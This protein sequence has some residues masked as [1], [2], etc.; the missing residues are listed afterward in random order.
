MNDVDK[1]GAY[2]PGDE[3]APANDAVALSLPKRVGRYRVEKVL[4]KGG[5]GLVYLAH[6]DQLH[7]LVAIKVPHA[8]LVVRSTDAEAYLTEA[9]T[10]ANLD[11][12]HIVPVFDV[13]STPDCPCFVVSKYIDGTDLSARLKQSRL[14][15]LEAV[16]LVATV[17]ETLHHAHKQGLVHRD[18]KPGNIL[19][20]KSG[21]PF[22]GD[23]GLALREQDVGKG[24]R[25]VGTPAYMSPEQA[26]CEG[27][28]VDGRSD[29]FSLGAVFY[30]LLVGHR[31]FKADSQDDLLDQIANVDVRPPRQWDDAIPKE[32]ERICLKSLSKRA[33][34]RYSA[35][36]DMADDLR[37][38]L[39]NASVESKPTL[40]NRGKS[41]AA[42]AT[43]VPTP[44][45]PPVSDRQPIKIVP[46]GLRSFDA[47]DADFF[48]ELL[49]GPRDREGLPDSIRFWKN[50]IEERDAENTFAVGL[51][52]GPSG[53]GKSSLVKA[54]LLP[55]LSDD[56]IAVYLEATAG[57]T[58]ARL[59][60]GLRKKCPA[61][62]ANIGVKETLAALRRGHGIPAG[63]KVLI[64]IDQFEQWLH[65]KMEVEN[66]DLV[67]ALRQCDGGRVQCIVMVRDDFWM[68]A[69]RFMRDLEVRLLEGQNSAAVDLFDMDHAK[70]VLAAF[71]RAFGK[72]PENA[73][74]ADKEQ[75]EFLKQAV[76]G[77]AQEGKVICVRLALFAEMMKGKAWTPASLR[78]VGGTEG[79]G[80]TFLEETFSTASSP[81]EHRYHQKAARADLRVL[82]PETGS[83]IKG[84][85][86]SYAELLEASGYGN[87]PK[88]F[89]ELLRI[90]D[91]EIRLI[92]PTDPEGKEADG[93]S[94]LQTKPGQKYY[95]LTHDYL[96]HSIREWLTRKQKETRRGRAELLLADRAA[97]WNARPENRQLPSLL[98]WF[99]IRLSAAKRNW[100]PPQS[101]M[102]RQAGR[103]HAMRGAVVAVVLALIGWGGYETRGAMRATA[104]L[105][106]LLDANTADVPI[107]VKDMESYR[108]WIDPLLRNASSDAEANKVARKQLHASL[109][110]LPVDPG[111][112]DYLS[113][114]LLDAQ[115]HEV[116]VI[117]DALAPHKDGLLDNL[118]SVVLTP[119]K[120]KQAQRLRAAAA[121]AKY[122][123]E[124]E[125]WTTSSPLVVTDLVQEN[126]VFLG[127]WSE[128]YRPVKNSLLDPLAVHFR[129]QRPE[130]SAERTLATNLLADYAVDNPAKL[131]DYLMDANDKQ[132]AMIYPKFKELGEKG[133]P[134]LVGVIDSILPADLPSSDEQ[135]ETR[136]KRQ[137]NAAVALLRMNQ[138]AKVWPLLKH[139]P[140]PRVRSYLIHWL[141][142]LG[143]DA[144]AILKQLDLEPDVTIR[145]AL[146]LSL[147]EF[148]QDALPLAARSALLPKLQALYR[149]D[150]DPGLHA[151]SEWLLRTWKQEAWL[152]QVNEEWAAD[153]DQRE[154]RFEGLRQL[155][156]KDE[157][158]TPPQWY[159]NGQGQTFVVIP[160][161]VEFV[162]G[163]PESEKDRNTIEIPHKKRIGR[164]FAIASKSVTLAEYRSL[165]NNKHELPERFS[166]DPKQPVAAINWYMAAQYC[167]LLSKVEGIPSD[168]WCYEIKGNAP[169]Y[170]GT[171]LTENYLSLTGYRLPTEAEMEYATRAGA[172][173]SRYYGETEDLLGHYAWY[174]KSSHDRLMPVGKKKPN[175]LGLFDVQGNCHLWCQDAYLE[176]PAV[177]DDEVAEDKE[178]ELMVN[179]VRQRVLRSSTFY[180]VAPNVRSSVRV[181]DA[182][183]YRGSIYSFRPARTF[184]P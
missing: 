74:E 99:Q 140:D 80:I 100:T 42:I 83:D 127:Q 133:L 62:P 117:R 63:K 168:Q 46:K 38:F 9:R 159:V 136:A 93:D 53:C 73:N 16:E 2:Q 18:I 26:R 184:I 118:W 10:V 3:D 48:L 59:L 134:L 96:V 174:A 78:A 44:T 169:N 66:A 60:N 157:A 121:L 135:R 55:R 49:P 132:F 110:L 97:V 50:R 51:I 175:D 172:K 108:R 85:M 151:A 158:K 183:A 31:L 180:Y 58:E 152:K 115:P 35:A 94:A 166:Y 7:R 33:S 148:G 71:G 77:L 72:L 82:L 112:V 75:K 25:Y 45:T 13:G 36:R 4:G 23:F 40:T 176:Y 101:K 181:A 19:L 20:D 14:S 17:A 167:N 141:S 87:R 145:R 15:L 107:I 5:F 124:N 149:T 92:T 130:R 179:S 76:S 88:D 129:D 146:L 126:P 95:Q 12:P 165:T 65:A 143:A 32:V 111:Q 125:K 119:E 144:T 57:E 89:D 81:P 79:V 24:P 41:D 21:K 67:Q 64:V 91:N 170:A 161:P 27:H 37:H 109:A 123:P 173:T 106:R 153:K 142:P 61:L 28:R 139:S 137:A 138:P 103:Y 160:G 150:A 68:A 29:I 120:G 102:M 69:T 171:R 156:K 177:N 52:Y 70:K 43:S 113:G 122:D 47:H 98:Q 34:E 154:K 114:R 1:T 6:D 30:E 128:M 104:L 182:P 39:E 131:A 84:H 56:V 162:M 11:H 116:P 178:G 22:V 90:L 163:S 86:R 147:G 155:V 54:G 105:D 164:S 8:R